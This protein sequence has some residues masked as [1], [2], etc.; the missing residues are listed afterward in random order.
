MH[1]FPFRI[2]RHTK[3]VEEIVA[4]HTI[5]HTRARDYVVHADEKVWNTCRIDRY[6]SHSDER[7]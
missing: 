6:T 2:E 7:H 5:D 4:E 3:P 1:E